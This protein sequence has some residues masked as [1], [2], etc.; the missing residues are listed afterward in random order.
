MVISIK[1]T[2]NI[3]SVEQN[4]A[5]KSV[6][7]VD[8][9]ANISN[10]LTSSN[11]NE[12]TSVVVA[13]ERNAAVHFHLNDKIEDEFDKRSS[14]TPTPPPSPIKQQQNDCDQQVMINDD[15]FIIFD[16]PQSLPDGS[17]NNLINNRDHDE[18]SDE[19][20]DDFIK[21]AQKQLNKHRQSNES[22]NHYVE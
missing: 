19:D 16:T 18:D 9:G 1:N 3:N 21:L 15:S 10:D 12:N 5:V 20:D 7:N 14:S 4:T 6:G 2:G 8:I 13:V 17:H 11:Q 22:L